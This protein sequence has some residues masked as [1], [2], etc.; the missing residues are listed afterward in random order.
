MAAETAHDAFTRGDLS[1]HRL[2]DYQRRWKAVFGKELRTGYYARVLFE[3][4]GDRQIER[5]LELCF[6]AQED[7]IGTREFSFDW[8]SK[9]ILKALS[10]GD[11]T[12]LFTSVGPAV[13]PALSR[14]V[15]AGS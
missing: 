10:R 8:H 3:A 1:A 4:L 15:R 14:L 13:V 6:D 11:F 2:K 7:L 9:V 12:K 5:L